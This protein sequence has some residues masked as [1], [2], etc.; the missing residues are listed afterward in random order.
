VALA[1]RWLTD[2]M[3]PLDE[4]AHTATHLRIDSL[5]FGVLIAYRYHRD[6][7][8]LSKF[9]NQNRRRLLLAGVIAIS[10]VFLFDVR[11]SRFG[12]AP[13]LTLF[14]VGSGLVMCGLLGMSWV[15][16]PLTTAIGLVG[17]N[18]Y[19]VYLWHNAVRWWGHIPLERILGVSLSPWQRIILYAVSAVLVGVVLGKLVEVP[20]LRLRDRLFP[21]K[22]R[23]MVLPDTP[24]RASPAPA[25]QP[26]SPASPS[27][28]DS[29]GSGQ[30]EGSAG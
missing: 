10:P 24:G 23:P 30:S 15:R 19:S 20:V 1:L 2:L 27:P 29:V 18:S 7:A 21:S 14:Y 8:G 6:P 3:L 12:Y 11:A 26:P 22:S 16:N 13:A 9:W 5:F 25:P 4:R 17:A 28:R